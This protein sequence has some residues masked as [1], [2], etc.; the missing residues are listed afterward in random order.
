[1]V[2]EMKYRFCFRTID[3]R[4]QFSLEHAYSKEENRSGVFDTRSF[5]ICVDNCE[6]QPFSR[7]D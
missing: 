1:M 5:C 7:H 3:G 4:S 6:D 2:W